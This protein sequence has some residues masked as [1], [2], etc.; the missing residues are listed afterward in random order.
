MPTRGQAVSMCRH[1]NQQRMVQEASACSLRQ[2]WRHA[3]GDFLVAG[4]THQRR[5]EV[6]MSWLERSQQE[7][8][9]P[10]I[11]FSSDPQLTSQLIPWCRHMGTT[12]TV[13]STQYRNYHFFYGMSDAEIAAFFRDLAERNGYTEIHTLHSFILAFLGVLRTQMIPS[14]PAM[15]SLARYDDL[16]IANL[17]RNLGVSPMHISVIESYAAAG[18]AFRNLL[19]DLQQTFYNLSDMQTRSE[20]NVITSV[21]HGYTEANQNGYCSRIHLV[22]ISS[23][24]SFAINRY[25]AGEI[26]FL[27]KNNRSFRLVL[28]GVPLND[29][30]RLLQVLASACASSLCT[31]GFCYANPFL[32]GLTEQLQGGLSARVI[33]LDGQALDSHSLET[34][35]NNYGSY[36]HWEPVRRNSRGFLSLLLA[37]PLS[38][39]WETEHMTRNRLRLED[40]LQRAAVLSGHSSTYVATVA[41][42]LHN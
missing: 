32:C 27:L 13:S 11:I 34:L 40:V 16:A 38:D 17:G 8:E 4:G 20:T 18:S 14:L 15:L 22:E 21:L 19:S 41:S 10:V 1:Y 23:S 29:S 36:E 24:E 42:V 30:E 6:L 31:V 35:L 3:G 2:F 5:R 7:S 9:L 25:M 28:D 37:N 39:E 33:L 26:R 12:L